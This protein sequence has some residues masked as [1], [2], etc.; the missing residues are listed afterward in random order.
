MTQYEKLEGKVVVY[1]DHK[2]TEWN[3]KTCKARVVGLDPDVGA[4]LV[5][6][7][8]PDHYLICVRG[9]MSPSWKR[10]EKSES[11]TKAESRERL[12]IYVGIMETLIKQIEAGV[13]CREEV[14]GS[15]CVEDGA[16]AETCAFS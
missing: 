5:D 7:E 1:S 9:P 8:D 15:R 3:K 11:P 12:Q 4:T 6:S 10:W 14:S 16:S 13:V 2:L